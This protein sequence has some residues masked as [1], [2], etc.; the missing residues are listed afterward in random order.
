[1]LSSAR[2]STS[3]LPHRG[4]ASSTTPVPHKFQAQHK[5]CCCVS[6][7]CQTV[8]YPG[9]SILVQGSRNKLQTGASSSFSFSKFLKGNSDAGI[10]SISRNVLAASYHTPAA[11]YA[12][13]SR[14]LLIS[15]PSTVF[16][17]LAQRKWPSAMG[18][19]SLLLFLFGLV[20]ALLATVR[21]ALVRRVKSCKCCRGFGIIRCRLCNGKGKVDWR[22][23]FSYSDSCPLCMAKRFVVCN[24]CGGYYHRRLF[25]HGKPV[26]VPEADGVLG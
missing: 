25:S 22:A 26:T 15:Q 9:S 24:E 6:L 13:I 2:P 21:S 14:V 8:L 18:P 16:R 10:V 3:Y 17:Q 19:I 7:T 4:G 1:M 11:S 12:S 5:H 20:V 23:K